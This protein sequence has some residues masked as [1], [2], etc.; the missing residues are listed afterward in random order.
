MLSRRESIDISPLGPSRNAARQSRSPTVR[1]PTSHSGSPSIRSITSQSRS[2]SIRSATSQSRPPVASKKAINSH[3]PTIGRPPLEG[4]PTKDYFRIL[5]LTEGPQAPEAG[6]VRDQADKLK[7]SIRKRRKNTE[8]FEIIRELEEQLADLREARRFFLQTDP[9]GA[10]FGIWW[11]LW[12]PRAAAFNLLKEPWTNE[13]PNADGIERTGKKSAKG[14]EPMIPRPS[15]D[16]KKRPRRTRGAK[17]YVLEFP[18]RRQQSDI[19]D[20][21]VEKVGSVDFDV[22]SA[23]TLRHVIHPISI[24]AWADDRISIDRD[25]RLEHLKLGKQAPAWFVAEN[26]SEARIA[27]IRELQKSIPDIPWKHYA[28]R[29]ECDRL[30]EA[31]REKNK[32]R[33]TLDSHCPPTPPPRPYNTGKS[34]IEIPEGVIWGEDLDAVIEKKKNDP[35]AR[36]GLE[37]MEP[38]ANKPK[39]YLERKAAEFKSGQYNGVRTDPDILSPEENRKIKPIKRH[40]VWELIFG[41]DEREYAHP[42]VR[43]L[44]VQ[45]RWKAPNWRLNNK[46][47]LE[48]KCVPG[49]S[50]LE[51][52]F[53]SDKHFIWPM[54]LPRPTGPSARDSFLRK[55]KQKDDLAES[56][57]T[58]LENEDRKKKAAEVL[59]DEEKVERRLPDWGFEKVRVHRRGSSLEREPL[60]INLPGRQEGQFEILDIPTDMVHMVEGIVS[61]EEA[62]RYEGQSQQN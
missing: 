58:K 22:A 20:D 21:E 5:G 60:S 61:D 52:L 46:Y 39:E 55:L 4:D 28:M 33:E 11:Q 51:H 19:A 23:D 2:P 31:T 53:Y 45:H 40:W 10:L 29:Q 8:S 38:R 37:Y 49:E 34:G 47:E 9:D 50:Y 48:H 24:R 16:G 1:S 3:S 7:R 17:T 32:R 44:P 56:R 54:E 41:K 43:H 35:S 13:E 42:E 27:A 25:R 14:K 15:N 30:V 57:K 18:Q 12:G 62:L 6:I 26:N 36:I 59:A